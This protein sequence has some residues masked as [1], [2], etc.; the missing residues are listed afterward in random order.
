MKR[1]LVFILILT[2]FAGPLPAADFPWKL[3]KDE[4]GVQVHVRPV[5]GSEI[6]EYKGAVTVDRPLQEVV[7]FYED[8]G[9]MPEWFH[10]CQESRLLEKKSETEKILYFALDL[11]WPVK[12]RDSVYRRIRTTDSATGRVEYHASVVP[13]ILPEYPGRIRMP[14][15]RGFW[16]F[17]PL[18]ENRTEI[19]YQQHGD[20]GGHIPAWLINQLAVS[21]PFHSLTRFRE[22]LDQTKKA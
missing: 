4:R 13:G 21:I 16:R 9:R 14:A 19:Y 8:A 10:Q 11:P 2:L 12:D 18:G 15:V 5:E 17:T 6:L 20:A 22:L 1:A 7:A 3:K